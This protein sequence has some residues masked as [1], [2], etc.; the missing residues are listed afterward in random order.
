MPRYTSGSGKHVSQKR[1]LT[2][3]EKDGADFW[4]NLRRGVRRDNAD[5]GPF[6]DRIG[7][8]KGEILGYTGI[9]LSAFM[10]FFGVRSYRENA[11]G[12]RL[13]FGRGFAVG[14]LITLIQRL[15]RGD[16]GNRLF[17]IHARLC[18]KICRPHGGACENVRSEPAKDG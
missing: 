12:G 10:V 11:G 4:A 8:E 5:Y 6:A 17:Q 16:L 9:V 3:H 7:W 13:I 14:I 15:L 18:G 2:F 1:R